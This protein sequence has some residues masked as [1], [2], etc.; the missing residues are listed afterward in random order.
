MFPLDRMPVDIYR[1][2]QSFLCDSNDFRDHE[3]RNFMNTNKALFSQIKYETVRYGIKSADLPYHLLQSLPLKM[4][5]SSKQLKMILSN[6]GSSADAEETGSNNS[7]EHLTSYFP[8][9][10]YHLKLQDFSLA[11]LLFS[12]FQSINKLELYKCNGLT[13][14]S[15][16][17]LGVKEVRLVQLANMVDINSLSACKDIRNVSI[18]CCPQLQDVS[19]LNGIRKVTIRFCDNIQNLNSLGN[20]HSFHF[21]GKNLICNNLKSFQYCKHLSI[22]CL[23]FENCNFQ[24]VEKIIGKLE[25][26]G[27]TCGESFNM[28]SFSGISLKLQSFHIL[29][30]QLLYNC[31]NMKI[32]SLA[33]CLGINIPELQKSNFFSFLKLKELFLSGFT[34]IIHINGMEKIPKLTL[35]H[36]PSLI[37]I[38]GLEKNI[39]VSFG[40][41]CN[42]QEIIY[43]HDI[44][45]LQISECP[46]LTTIS[47][48]TNVST[49]ALFDCA[50][51]SDL[52][53]LSETNSLVL[54]VCPRL[55]S[56]T[57]LNKV[58]EIDIYYCMNLENINDLGNNENV[59]IAKCPKISK[60]YDEG[61]YQ[62]LKKSIPSF[63]VKN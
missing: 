27:N 29:N 10:L 45:Y 4:K 38:K 26:I 34:D 6:L 23:S 40:H 46:S 33:D 15:G 39:F 62:E 52:S 59:Q 17:T 25:L 13:S 53:E 63:I 19:C 7:L 12:G 57:G 3:Y 55:Y 50:S 56:L 2:I 41:L 1:V 14:L 49:I 16:L 9:G 11:C 42:L 32:L 47:E 35:S 44:K 28:N 37:S 31:P 58:K 30:S 48:M 21:I 18:Y 43:C 5:D 22:T 8:D 61:C 60:L 20:H 24:N 36:L 51:M 54:F